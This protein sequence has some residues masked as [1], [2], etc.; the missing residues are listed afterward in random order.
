M[1]S[2]LRRTLGSNSD[3]CISVSNLM[4][5]YEDCTVYLHQY[6]KHISQTKFYISAFNFIKK[7]ELGNVELSLKVGI[8][9]RVP[10]HSSRPP[11]P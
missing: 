11:G 8:G 3:I 2:L 9:K 5:R 4:L 1:C 10:K 6:H 7:K